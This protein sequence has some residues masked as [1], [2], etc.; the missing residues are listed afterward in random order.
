MSTIICDLNAQMYKV[1]FTV[2]SWFCMGRTVI[3]FFFAFLCQVSQFISAVFLI[4]LIIWL[5]WFISQHRFFCAQRSLRQQQFL[6][7]PFICRLVIVWIL[8]VF[9][10]EKPPGS[11]AFCKETVSCFQWGVRKN[12][13][14]F[15]RR[16]N[17]WSNMVPHTP[18]LILEVLRFLSVYVSNFWADFPVMI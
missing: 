1:S 8:L 17:H 3:T 15:W 12:D 10:V 11:Q 18:Q 16:S 2:L 6:F 9:T 7:L 14:T 4:L 13:Y 5:G